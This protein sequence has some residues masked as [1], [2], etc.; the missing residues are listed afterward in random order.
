MSVYLVFEFLFSILGYH[1]TRSSLVAGFSERKENFT[2]CL[3]RLMGG[4]CHHPDKSPQSIANNT[5]TVT[6]AVTLA[7]LVSQAIDYIAKLYI[8]MRTITL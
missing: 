6:H 1:N 5:C 7:K 4:T 2:H 3:I 8:F